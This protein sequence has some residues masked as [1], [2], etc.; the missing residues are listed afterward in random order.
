MDDHTRDRTQRLCERIWIND[1]DQP[2]QSHVLR[3]IEQGLQDRHVLNL[4][5]LDA[6]ENLTSRQVDPQLLANRDGYWYLIAHCQLRG[7][8]RWFRLDRIQ[9]TTLTPQAAIEVP[10]ETI[11]E[12]PPS[13]HR[14]SP[15]E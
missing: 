7:E 6:E 2:S 4:I 15:R 14:I 11:G 5:Y 8:I 13:A 3:P 12:P 9:H 1:A 10:L